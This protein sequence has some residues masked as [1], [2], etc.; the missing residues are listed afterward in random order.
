MSSDATPLRPALLV[1][2]RLRVQ[3]AN[4]ISSPMTWGFPA[5]SNFTGFMTALERR[6]GAD[7][8]IEL[9]GV[10]VICHGHEAQVTRKGFVRSF[11]LTR[12][13]VGQDG[14]T[15][16]IVEEG[17]IHLDITLVFD[18]QLG[19]EHDDDA[20][21]DALARRIGELI[22]GM[23]IAGGSV[24]PPLA[25][26]DG[27][28]PPRPRF[29]PVPSDAAE[30]RHGFRRL[31][32]RWLPG[33]ALVARDDLLQGRLAELQAAAAPDAPPASVLDA[34]LDIS[35]ITHRC[36]RSEK[37]ATDGGEP[38]PQFDWITEPRK[39]W[40]VP[41]PVGFAA[42]G[43]LHAPGSVANARDAA[44]PFRFV[45]SAL[46]I[47]QWLSPHRLADPAELFWSTGY[48]EATGLYRAHNSYTPPPVITDY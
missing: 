38:T 23:R 6:L 5:I 15:A 22:A 41:I 13:P 39:G 18:A 11:H 7:S 21:L 47:G 32:R 1:I 19:P 16:A 10:G 48:D 33:F 9:H 8:S 28:P 46:S 12:N 26:A 30:R 17:R 35:R 24:M 25:T 44:T 4:A 31:A 29:W 34:W 20:K 3:N 27:R 45:E 43:P 14:G 36:V 42:L 2:P 37:P 40:L